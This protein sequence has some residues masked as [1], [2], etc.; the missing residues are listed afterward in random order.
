MGWKLAIARGTPPRAMTPARAT[1]AAMMHH[2][3]L[4]EVDPAAN[5]VIVPLE[6]DHP[7]REAALRRAAAGVDPGPAEGDEFAG[8][9]AA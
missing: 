9:E 1:W 6:W 3:E 5:Y 2:I 8:A 7:G 4:F